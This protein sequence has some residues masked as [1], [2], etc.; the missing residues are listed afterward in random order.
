[1]HTHWDTRAHTNARTH[2]QM[3]TCDRART[4]PAWVKG[5]TLGSLREPHFLAAPSLPQPGS[6]PDRPTCET[7]R[8]RPELPHPPSPQSLCPRPPLRPAPSSAG[9][10]GCEDDGDA[11]AEAP[12][13]RRRTGRRSPHSEKTRRTGRLTRGTLGRGRGHFKSR[14]GAELRDPG[15]AGTDPGGQASVQAG[16]GAS[17][18]EQQVAFRESRQRTPAWSRDGTRVR[19]ERHA[20]AGHT[21][22]APAAAKAHTP[23]GAA[24]CAGAG[25]GHHRRRTGGVAAGGP[26]RGF[27]ATGVPGLRWA[28]GCT[29]DRPAEGQPAPRQLA[30]VLDSQA[31]PSPAPRRPLRVQEV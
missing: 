1:M 14:L 19:C 9:C 24:P 20:E 30:P 11:A 10:T 12:G 21:E 7:R 3:N 8:P 5:N 17:G 18:R 25:R 31:G 16:T 13:Q 15:P 22:P 26:R 23:P 28:G 27:R 4:W 29:G 2:T 6:F